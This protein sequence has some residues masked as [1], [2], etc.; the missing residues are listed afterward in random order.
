M[1]IGKSNL[2]T[3]I[4]ND[5]IWS[6]SWLADHIGRG[7]EHSA[8][9][10]DYFNCCQWRRGTNGAILKVEGNTNW[11][12]RLLII[13]SIE[14]EGQRLG[15]ANRNAN[16]KGTRR[17]EEKRNIQ[18]KYYICLLVPLD[19]AILRF[20]LTLKRLGHWQSF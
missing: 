15:W 6:S 10:V 20:R 4:M 8:I 2:N 12:S 16:G 9:G 19:T 3:L 14:S 17:N 18:I 7:L 1:W 13:C 11:R 5:N